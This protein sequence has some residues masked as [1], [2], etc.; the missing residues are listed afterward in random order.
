MKPTTI[1]DVIARLDEII[2]WAQSKNS[3]LGYFPALYRKVTIKVKEGIASG[4]FD[5]GKRMERLD[6]NFANRYL[7]AFESYRNQKPTPAS[8]VLSFQAAERWWS[9]VLQHLLL[10]INAHINLD[11]GMAAAQTSPGNEIHRLKNDF[12]RI[13]DILASLID[14]VTRQLTLVWPMLKLLDKIAGKTDD[15]IINFSINIARGEAW[16]V[17]T[18]FATLN[19]S[20]TAQR[21]AELDKH[22]AW[23]GGRVRNPGFLIG[24]VTKAV[25]LG[26]RG[27]NAQI[28]ETLSS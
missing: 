15:A 19:S 23:I 6:V 8:W 27:T 5:D 24:T 26:E 18:E 17:A 21:G 9:I 14:D 22:V 2:D 12:N 11:L 7:E 1:D 28:I 13:N 4:H 10:G 3:R 25:R 16:K 20:V